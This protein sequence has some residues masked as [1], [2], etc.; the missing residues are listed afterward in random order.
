MPSIQT[1]E[2]IARCFNTSVAYLTGET[3]DIKPDSFVIFKKDN[4]ALFELVASLQNGD[5]GVIKRM[6]AY[7]YA[8]SKEEMD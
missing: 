5:D 2:V 6:L 8:I 3:D 4:P 7:Y 1:L